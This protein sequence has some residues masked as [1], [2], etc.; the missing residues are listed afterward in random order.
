MASVASRWRRRA[1]S[2]A[3][4]VLLAVIVPAAG[5]PTGAYEFGPTVRQLGPEQTVFDWTTQRCDDNNVPDSPARAFKDASNKVQLTMSDSVKPAHDR[6]H[7]WTPSPWTARSRCR[8]TGTPI[9][10][11]TTTRSGCTSPWTPDG[12][13]VF[14]LVHEE[15]QGWDHPGMCAIAGAPSRPKLLDRSDRRF[16]GFD[17]TCWY[18]S[19]TLATSTNGGL[20][21][22]H[23]SRPPSSPRAFPINT[24]PTRART[25]TS[26]RATSS[27][28]GRLLLRAGA[29]AQ[30]LREARSQIGTC[31]DAHDAIWLDPTSWRAWDGTGFNVKFIN[32]YLDPEPARA[33]RLP[34]GLVQRDREDGPEHHATTP[35]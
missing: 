22:T 3:V 27:S 28:L 18:N 7:A 15:Y 6:P 16:A 4:G 11:P 21:Y 33:A 23:A 30:A 1:T 14:A 34:A 17:P 12:N 8:R 5:P 20:T 19:I 26:T 32:P 25:A 10:P 24:W 35:S 13:N 31:V 9:P 29:Y 2:L